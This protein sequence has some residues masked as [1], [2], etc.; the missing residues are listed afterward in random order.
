MT[1]ITFQLTCHFLCAEYGQMLG[2]D[3]FTTYY[4][5]I[6]IAIIDPHWI[7]IILGTWY[8][9]LFFLYP[10]KQRIPEYVCFHLQRKQYIFSSTFRESD[11]G[12]M[13]TEAI[14]QITLNDCSRKTP[15]LS[16]LAT[17]IAAR[18]IDVGHCISLQN[19]HYCSLN[20][21]PVSAPALFLPY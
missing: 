9:N 12:V 2:K 19:H 6:L 11:L 1:L 20:K 5:S 16:L 21:L 13:Q 14:A 10:K 18:T 15:L 4:M 17:D 8:G 7:T 3:Y